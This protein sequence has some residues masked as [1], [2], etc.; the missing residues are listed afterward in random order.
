MAPASPGSMKEECEKRG[1]PIPKRIIYNGLYVGRHSLVRLFRSADKL[2]KI[3]ILGLLKK[4]ALSIV[5]C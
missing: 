4:W 1:F 5:Y 3:G 2:V